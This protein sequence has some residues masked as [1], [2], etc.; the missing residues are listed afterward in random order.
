MVQEFVNRLMHG[1][2]SVSE[3]RVKQTCREETSGSVMDHSK[4]MMLRHIYWR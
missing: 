3:R 4:L 1:L 2:R